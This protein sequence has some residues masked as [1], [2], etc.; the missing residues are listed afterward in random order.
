MNGPAFLC[1]R[2]PA[3]YKF[4]VRLT[5]Y[6]GYISGC[7]GYKNRKKIS[8]PFHLFILCVGIFP[9][10]FWFIGYPVA[11]NSVYPVHPQSASVPIAGW[12]CLKNSI[13]MKK[14]IA[15]IFYHDFFA[16]E[17]VP[18]KKNNYFHSNIIIFKVHVFAGEGANLSPYLQ[19][20][21]LFL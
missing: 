19:M 13:F 7:D 8:K 3:G 15:C 17:V 21:F 12:W 2:W 9:I 6:L 10:F 14:I 20:F 5:G 1:I 16:I 4:V 18:T 11:G